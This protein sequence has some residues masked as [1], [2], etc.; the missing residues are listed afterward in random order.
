MSFKVLFFASGN[1]QKLADIQ[2]LAGSVVEFDIEFH[3]INLSEPQS[4]DLEYVL[5]SKAEEA[6]N[7]LRRPLFV[8]HTSL[9]LQALGGHP[10]TNSS[11]FWGAIGDDICRIVHQLGDAKATVA[12]GLTYTDSKNFYT[13]VKRIEGTIS[14]VPK[15]TR[16]F[17][18]DLVFIPDGQKK[19][20]GEMP[21]EEK[22]LYSP[23]SLAFSAMIEHV[24]NNLAE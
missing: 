10:G 7:K 13:F 9:E 14:T 2:E 16:A 24:K 5:V 19:T 21:V 11:A 3:K 18:W 22:N 1:I 23:R 6:F 8:D 4:N 12:V 15:G 17:D 20:Y